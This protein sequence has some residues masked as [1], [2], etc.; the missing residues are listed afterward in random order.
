MLVSPP[1]SFRGVRRTDRPADSE[2]LL[3]WAS[4]RAA[5]LALSVMSHIC[6][7]SARRRCHRRRRRRRLGRWRLTAVKR[8]LGLAKRASVQVPRP[9]G[10]TYVT[11]GIR[12][13]RVLPNHAKGLPSLPRPTDRWLD[14]SLHS[15]SWRSRCGEYT[16]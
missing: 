16:T 11:Q 14:L 3:F 10:R 4:E 8:S 15:A 1:P 13:G 12:S 2:G 9:A 7:I 6:P 5:V